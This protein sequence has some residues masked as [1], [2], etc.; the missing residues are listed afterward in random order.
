M[1]KSW[2]KK[3]FVLSYDVIMDENPITQVSLYR[4]GNGS[5]LRE[6]LASAFPDAFPDAFPNAPIRE[7]D[8]PESGT[9]W[10]AWQAGTAGAGRGETSPATKG[11]AARG[12]GDFLIFEQQRLSGAKW[13]PGEKPERLAEAAMGWLASRISRQGPIHDAHLFTV[14]RQGK[15]ALGGPA[16]ALRNKLARLWEGSSHP[17]P[18]CWNERV[19]GIAGEGGTSGLVAQFLLAQG[20]LWCAVSPPDGLVSPFPGGISPLKQPEGAPS[21]SALKLEESWLLCGWRPAF[22]ETVIDLGAA[23]GGWTHACLKRGCRVMAVDNASLRLRDV[24]DLPGTLTH[25]RADGLRFR[26][27]APWLPV[28]WLL[29]DMLIPP[30]VCLGLLKKWIGNGWMRRFVVNLKLPQREPLAALHPV[31][32]YLAGVPG[33]PGSPGFWWRMRQLYHD[34]REVTVMGAIPGELKPSAGGDSAP[35]MRRRASGSTR[36]QPAA[37]PKRRQPAADT[38]KRSG[39]TGKR[40]GVRSRKPKT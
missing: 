25:V 11:G 10:I 24:D 2:R 18:L 1:E 30:G 15:A 23:P 9:G 29:V 12:G 35:P 16:L 26:P 33:S 5:W 39:K 36:R 22:R 21:R 31:R 17:P 8:H 13:I 6:E 4:P 34:R 19:A 14:D 28:D 38:G 20:G 32:E 27:P 7:A 40:R 3:R 37:A